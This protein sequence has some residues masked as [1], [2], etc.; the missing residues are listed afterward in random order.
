MRNKR[1]LSKAILKSKSAQKII[2]L[3]KQLQSVENELEKLYI[4]RRNKQE[5]EA[6]KNIK[7]NPKF[8]Y[9][10][11]KKFTKLKTYIEFHYI[12]IVF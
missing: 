8:F 6:I 2:A 4:A 12:M 3:R 9:T 5:N 10:Y 7:K 11:A 1:N